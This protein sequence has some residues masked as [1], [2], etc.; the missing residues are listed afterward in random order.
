MLFSTIHPLNV[1]LVVC[2]ELFAF[3]FECVGDQAR[4]WRPGFSTQSDLLGNFKSLQ[5]GWSE[6]SRITRQLDRTSNARSKCDTNH[7]MTYFFSTHT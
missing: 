6:E 2:F 1:L 7:G 3:Q 4:L 5:F